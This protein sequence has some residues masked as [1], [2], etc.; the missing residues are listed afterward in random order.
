MT[1]LPNNNALDPD[2]TPSS[3][4]AFNFPTLADILTE[5]LQ[6]QRIGAFVLGLHGP[7][8]SGKTT[9][10]R[11]IEA[12]L[13]ANA[14]V[15]NFN[16][17]K[18]QG[19]EALW[20]AL[21]LHVLQALRGSAGIDEKEIAELQRSLYESFM[22]KEQGPLRV[23]W[24]A[25]I[26]EAVVMSASLAGLGMGGGLI[27][28]TGAFFGKVFNLGSEKEKG[29]D[30]QKHVERVAGILQREATERA[31]RQVVSIE[32][33]LDTFQ[34]LTAKLTNGTRIYVLIDDL[35]RCLPDTTLD[36]FEAMKLFLDAKE[37]SYIVAVDRAVIRRG[38]A[39][40]Y[41]PPT[42]AVAPPVVDA[43]EYIEKTIS[44]SFDLPA[45]GDL[46]AQELLNVVGL[47]LPLT[48]QQRDAVIATLG[49]N[50]RR[51]KRFGATLAIW[52]EVAERAAPSGMA[53]L[54][55]KPDN[56]NLFLKLALI[57]YINSAVIAQMQRDPELVDRLQQIANAVDKS[58]PI[59][60]QQ[61]QIADALSAELVVV[62]EAGLDPVL[63]RALK[64]APNLS[65]LAELPAAMRWFRSLQQPVK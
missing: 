2:D 49:T 52:Q 33:F 40:R 58:K 53:F 7:W 11:A 45:L 51:L 44:L 4:P 16:A 21:I 47:R 24:A 26:T 55:L 46:D 48:A 50:P 65:G 43:D 8:G 61:K 12:R 23:N 29:E 54:P 34:H 63:W 35:D 10:M 9:L 6:K 31:V 57:G 19:R 64:L 30:A 60:D 20:R 3:N 18:Y 56:V 39:L 17:W 22:V 42:E 38:L 59:Q 14:I 62:R 41:P 37:C 15:V 13:P 5:H 28:K 1:A 32:Q 36:I 25:A 27:R